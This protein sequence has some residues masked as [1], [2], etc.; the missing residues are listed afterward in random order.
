MLKNTKNWK[1]QGKPL[2]IEMKLNL[3]TKYKQKR[4][5][6]IHTGYYYERKYFGVL[7]N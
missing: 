1:K 5:K 2:V 3:K 7:Q 6:Q 4:I